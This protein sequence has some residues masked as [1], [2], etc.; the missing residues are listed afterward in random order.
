MTIPFSQPVVPAQPNK[1]SY[2]FSE[3]ALFKTYTRETFRLAFGVEA[4]AFD[5]SRVI[6]TWFDST[7]DTT[8]AANVAVYKVAA[9]DS[10]GSWGL[11]QLVLPASEAATVNLPGAVAYPEYVIA[12]TRAARAGV[13][14]IWPVNLSLESDA[15]AL[16]SE[17]GLAGMPLVDEGV[18]TVFPINYADDPR[19]V[20]NFVYKGVGYNVG[21]LLAGKN[22]N[23]VGAPGHWT[24][25]DTIEWVAAPPAP[26]GAGDQRPP[27]EVPVRELLPNEKIGMTLMGPTILRTDRQQVSAEL[28]GQFTEND[29]AMLREIL[30]RVSQ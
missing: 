30:R 8:D 29:R 28:S 12:P 13:S 22:R 25:A 9:A 15:R 26:T 4:P 2:G 7:V 11:R 24:V 10:K 27:R 5:P 16:L 6:K 1:D 14:P 19:R 18:G 21:T 23:G 3:L 17:L 20:W